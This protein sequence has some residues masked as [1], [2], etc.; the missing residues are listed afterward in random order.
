MDNGQAFQ[1]PQTPQGQPMPQSSGPQPMPQNTGAQPMGQPM[2]QPAGVNVP[3]PIPVAGQAS[4]RPMMQQMPAPVVK[5]DN[6]DLIKIIVIIALSLLA[7]TFI[8]LFIW[9]TVEA[10][11]AQS[12]LE[13]KIDVAVA[14]ATEKQADKLE[15]EFAKREK[16]PYRPFTG[17]VDY[18]QLSFEY[19]K[20]WSV[21]VAEAA[22]SGGDYNAYFNPLQVEAVSKE[23]INALRVYIL[24]KGFD[25]VTK[26]YQ[27]YVDDED[28]PL[29]IESVTI[30]RKNNI[31]ANRYSGTIPDTELSGFI[32]TFKIRD[33]TVILQT[34]SVLFEEDFN[35]VLG[36]VTFNE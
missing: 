23:T 26:K 11:D 2:M 36:T 6:S 12:D 13:E 20:T 27:K 3:Q 25:E 35:R 30:G 21:Y 33:K 29:K 24:N 18:G 14:E 4:Y 5:K 1:L 7:V 19:P 15:E 32:V 34:D 31:T 10:N 22:T 17:P 9:K 16:D 28:N 8:G